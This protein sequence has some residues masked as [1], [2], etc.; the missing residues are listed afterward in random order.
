MHYPIAGL[1][2]SLTN[3][4]VVLLYP[5]KKIETFSFGYSLSKA[6]QAQQIDRVVNITAKIMSFLKKD[7]PKLIG[8]ED[9]AF[10]G[11]KLTALADLG[12]CM[13]AQV[14]AAFQRYPVSLASASIRSFLFGKVP[15]G[16]DRKEFVKQSLEAMGYEGCRN[17]DEWDALAVA[18]VLESYMLDDRRGD[19]KRNNVFEKISK[20]LSGGCRSV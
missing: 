7:P 9:Y 15:R 14:V 17:Y 3:S 4:G 5:D 12:G 11:H 18:L 10:K 13:K 6:T 19:K 16:A 8:L 2:L 20:E 1:D